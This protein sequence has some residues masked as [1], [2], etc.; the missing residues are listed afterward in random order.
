MKNNVQKYRQ[1]RL[2]SIKRQHIRLQPLLEGEDKYGHW[3]FEI[4]DPYDPSSESYG[5]WPKDLVNLAKTLVGVDGELNATSRNNTPLRDQT[6]RVALRDP[7]HGDD[8]DETFHPL[9]LV[10]DRRSDEKIVHCLRKF[11][12]SYKGK[13]QWVFE[14]GQNCHTFLLA[15]LEYCKLIVP[16]KYRSNLLPK[17]H[18][19]E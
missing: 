18:S 16:K 8:A 5:W 6:T 11:A 4:G 10:E 9:V 2:I 14:G 17:K 15:A 7:H 19:G 12:M 3:W 13:W 1:I